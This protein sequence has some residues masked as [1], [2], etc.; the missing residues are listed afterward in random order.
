MALRDIFKRRKKLKEVPE[1]EKEKIPEKKIVQSPALE[2]EK[3]VEK[4]R[5]VLA[6]KIL[7]SP[8]IT[9]KSTELAERGQYTFKVFEDANKTEIEK[10]I[11]QLYGVNVEAVRII[12]KPSKRRRRGREEGVKPGFKKAIVKIKEGQKIDVFPS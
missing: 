8:Y 10:A 4:K 3:K 5:P 9:E 6:Y 2:K 12:K 11:E 1:K 7:K